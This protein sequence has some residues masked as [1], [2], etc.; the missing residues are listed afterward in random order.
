VREQRQAPCLR[1]TVLAL[2]LTSKEILLVRLD[3]SDMGFLRIENT[4]DGKGF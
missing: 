3:V 1:K 4:F 2:R